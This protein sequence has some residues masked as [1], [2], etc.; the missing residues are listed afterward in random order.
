MNKPHYFKGFAY[1]VML[2][3]LAIIGVSLGVVSQDSDTLLKR[4][5]ELDWVFVGKQYQRAI[6]SY[7][8]QSPEGIKTLP[9]NLEELIEDKRFI[10][11]KHHLRKN[12]GDPANFN[13]AWN[14]I[15]NEQ[16][17]L[18]GVRS[19]SLQEILS[20]KIA[21]EFADNADQTPAKYSDVKFTFKQVLAPA[22]QVIDQAAAAAESINEPSLDSDSTLQDGEKSDA[23]GESSNTTSETQSF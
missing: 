20:T 9:H 22:E 10:K 16:N 7:Y 13:Q 8:Q 4:E 6:A 2:F 1:M 3:L 17:Q 23:D 14:L 18:T 15:L 11:P 5:K 19:N 12:Y 21:K